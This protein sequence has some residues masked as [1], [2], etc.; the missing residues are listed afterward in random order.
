MANIKDSDLIF[1]FI[2][3][4]FG[5]SIAVE[6]PT[7]EDGKRYIGIVDCYSATKTKKYLKKIYDARPFDGVRFI[8]ATHPHLD[9]IGGIKSLMTDDDYRPAQF[10]DSGFRHSSAT[11]QKILKTVHE[12]GIEMHRVSSGMEWYFGKVRVTALAP[13]MSLRLRYATYGVDMNNASIVLRFEHCTDD[14]VAIESLR[15]EGTLDPELERSAGNS[16]AIL[17]GDAELDSWAQVGDEYPTITS[18]S[19]NDPLVKKMVNLLN[20]SL[21]K[22]AHHGSMHS[23]PLD[24][25]ERMSPSVAVVSNKQQTSTLNLPDESYER[26]LFPHRIT[27]LA[28]KEVKAEV[29]TTDAVFDDDG[30]VQ[31]AE[32]SVIAVISQ[33]GKARVKKLDDTASGPAP[34]L[35][36]SV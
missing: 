33:G 35:P 10:W 2:N 3:V 24:I 22:V 34:D 23:A 1:H 16:V 12:E 6:L 36:V 14:V 31:S 20:C 30:N 4:G 8:C 5:D 13:S 17:A 19:K 9:H 29:L 7:D 27:S 32:G 21:L 18:T 11:Y 28:L 26:K 15:Y 25:L